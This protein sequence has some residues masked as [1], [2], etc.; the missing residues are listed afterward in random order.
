MRK[1]LEIHIQVVRE[2][3][4]PRTV[5]ILARI[6]KY[7]W[8]FFTSK[9]AVITFAQ[10]LKERQIA[11]PLSPNIAAVGP[12]T[13]QTLRRLKLSVHSIPK[14]FTSHDL[15]RSIGSIADMC[16]L[17]PRSA[18]ANYD[19]VRELRA[20]GARVSAISLYTSVVKPLPKTTLR[21]LLTGTYTQIIFKSPSAVHG[22]I[23]QLSKKERLTVLKISAQ[24][25][26][27]T[28]ARAARS[29]GFTRVFV[30]D[31]IIRIAKTRHE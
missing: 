7:D 2:N 4:S 20:R 30:K 11:M 22:L 6:E 9:N 12:A 31:C 25:I 26:G 15:I 14:R 13:A 5:H 27:P 21:A 10:E 1:I 19:V 3:L 29:V 18:I 23:K 16:I 17:F 28:T 8:I 24:C